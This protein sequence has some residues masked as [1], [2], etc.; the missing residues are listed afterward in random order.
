MKKNDESL[1]GN[2]LSLQQT[3]LTRLKDRVVELQRV[4]AILMNGR[5]PQHEIALLYHLAHNFAGS[6]KTFGYPDISRSA[7]MLHQALQFQDHAR[8]EPGKRETAFML[9]TESF[10]YFLQSCRDALDHASETIEPGIRKTAIYDVDAVR[11]KS[12]ALITTRRTEFAELLR[13][14]QHFGYET[15]C[16]ETMSG[17]TQAAI[18]QAPYAVL[19]DKPQVEGDFCLA[20]PGNL[21]GGDTRIPVIMLSPATDFASRLEAVRMGALGYLDDQSDALRIIEKIEKLASQY[22]APSAYRVLIVEEDEILCEFYSQTLRHAG[23]I[24][25]HIRNPADV[26]AHLAEYPADIILIDY[27]MPQCSGLELAAVLRQ[28]DEYLTL[29]IIFMSAQEDIKSQTIS[30]TLGVDDF[31]IKP[32]TPEQMI[33]VI[34]SRAHRAAEL[35]S[36]M[37]R[38]SFTGLLNHAYFLDLLNLERIHSGR[39]RHDT[40]YALIDLDHFKRINDTHGHACGDQVLKALSRLLQQRLRR[41]DI[42]GRC[43]GEEFGIIMPRCNISDAG[44]ILEGLRESFYQTEHSLNGETV[45][46]SFSGGYT[47]IDPEKSVDDA[48][49]AADAALYRSKNAGRNQLTL[50]E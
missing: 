48:I 6:G 29:P 31:L 40:V 11:T 19:L 30:S 7:R 16:Y 49:K 17:L 41:S 50:H 12:I 8:R 3:Y 13:Q 22:Y 43:G 23:M 2:F 18:T 47:R 15:L 45:K 14:L 1:N 26:P 28:H 33:S 34:V 44:R 37:V 27:N 24:T 42:I 10:H 38:D 21:A 25:S 4:E 36:L 20:D 46:I 39:Y 32:F 5:L 35:Q 9:I